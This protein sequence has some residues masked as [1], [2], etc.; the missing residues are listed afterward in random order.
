[1]NRQTTLLKSCP[2]CGSEDLYVDTEVAYDGKYLYVLCGDC[3][4]SGPEF[5]LD[6]FP[7]AYTSAIK[8]W[9]I[10]KTGVSETPGIVVR[11]IPGKVFH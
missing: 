8:N 9:N 4:A 11:Q 2:F 1:M 10:R 5:N 6:L 3:M 7:D